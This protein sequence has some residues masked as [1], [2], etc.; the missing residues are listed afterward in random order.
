MNKI[1]IRKISNKKFKSQIESTVPSVVIAA[2]A[3]SNNLN[4]TNT[5]PIIDDNSI[6][7]CTDI[8]SITASEIERYLSNNK[9]KIPKYN[10]AVYNK[11]VEF[12][13]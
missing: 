7:G 12:T 13:W 3:N 4:K 1:V 11:S 5:K 6:I 10:K 2:I 9:N 8:M